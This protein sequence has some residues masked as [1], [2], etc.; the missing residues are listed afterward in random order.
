MNNVI[1]GFKLALLCLILLLTTTTSHARGVYQTNDAFLAEVFNGTLPQSDVVWMKG[2]VRQTV[3]DILGHP[4]AGLRIRY[5]REGQRSAWIL[6]EIGKEEPITFGVVIN[7]DRVEQVK[8]LA[9]RESRGGEVKYPAFTQQFQNVGLVDNRLDK[10]IDGIT[11]ATL[12]VRAMTNVVR[13]ALYLDSSISQ[14]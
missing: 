5:W 8:V 14:S 6:E 1:S 10:H 12:S 4:Y 3:A 11:G 7:G 2:D 13:L 9:Y